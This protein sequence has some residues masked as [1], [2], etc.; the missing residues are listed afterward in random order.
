MDEIAQR[1]GLKGWLD[2]GG[3][4]RLVPVVLVYLALY[5]AAGKLLVLATGDWGK[6]DLLDSTTTVF[7]QLTFAL[8]VGAVILAV[9]TAWMGWNSEIYGRQ[10][11]YRSWWMWLGPIIALMPIILRVLGFDWASRPVSVI[12][13]VLVS[14]LFIGF[15]EEL[16][17]RGIAVKM[18]RDGGHGEL[19]V[20]GLSSLVFAVLHG[21]NL[22]SGQ[23]LVT[24]GIQ[25]FYT[26][27]FGVLMY[28]T[29]R[30]SRYLVVA[31]VVHGLTDPTAILA[32]SGISDAANT[33][34]LSPL[35]A[36]GGQF[37]LPIGFIGIVLLL[38]VRGR[39]GQTS[40]HPQDAGAS[41][42]A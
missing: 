29:L 8:V 37:T 28:L 25:M 40:K 36:A 14:G 24:T 13:L 7:V 1:P 5:L 17:C 9:F 3:F 23:A 19:V 26:F 2:K 18:L 12:A 35:A 38:C 41:A 16:L 39:Y 31:M 20:A 4:W 22:L 6:G 42:A 32:N 34:G 10:R 27:G 30:T 33:A 11:I 15:V 21:V